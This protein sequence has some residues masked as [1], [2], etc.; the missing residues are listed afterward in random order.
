MAG[1]FNIQ[2]DEAIAVDVT[3]ARQPDANESIYGELGKGP[4]I[5][6]SPVLDRRMS[7]A[8]IDIAKIYAIPYQTE[9]MGSRTGTNAD[10]IQ[11]C[12]PGVK[13]AVLSVPIRNMHTS[14]EICNVRDV[15]Y[16]A[17]LLAEYLLRGGNANAI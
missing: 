6:F 10:E 9:V 4:M 17:H 1:A 12:G 8:L 3:F 15:E 13:C 14:G 7:K 2:P 5:G 16:T 11:I